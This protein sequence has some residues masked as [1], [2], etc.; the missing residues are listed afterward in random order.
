MLYISINNLIKDFYWAIADCFWSRKSP[1]KCPSSLRVWKMSIHNCT[2]CLPQLYPQ[3][4][5]TASVNKACF[6]C[7]VVR[8]IS[9]QK[10][11]HF[12]D[13]VPYLG[14]PPTPVDSLQSASLCFGITEIGNQDFGCRRSYSATAEAPTPHGI[15]IYMINW[16]HMA[17]QLMLHWRTNICFL[18]NYK[19]PLNILQM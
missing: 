17:L 3:I 12:P 14:R 7:I 15:W 19:T 8:M 4:F 18:R 16:S 5:H 9:M 1:V 11:Q 10:Q 2:L 6:S 13:H